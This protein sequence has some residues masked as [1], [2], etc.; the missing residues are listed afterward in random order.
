[1]CN[2]KGPDMSCYSLVRLAKPKVVVMSPPCH[3]LR[4]LVPLTTNKQNPEAYARSLR[5]GVLCSRLAAKI[6]ELQIRKWGHL[7]FWRIHKAPALFTRDEWQAVEKKCLLR[8]VHFPQC[9]LGLQSP[10][11]E[12]I[13]KK[14]TL[15]SNAENLVAPFRHVQCQCIRPHRRIEGSLWL[16]LGHLGCRVASTDV[17]DDCFRYST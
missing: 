12:P 6:A 13:Q 16:L 17:S 7:F 4:T 11:G 3:S 1:M 8:Q 15:W 5:N 2:H 10:K 9:A 14:T